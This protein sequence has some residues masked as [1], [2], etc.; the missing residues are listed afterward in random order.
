VDY[1]TFADS[2]AHRARVSRD[3]ADTLIFETL[4]VL[5]RTLP[6]K[7]AADL[8]AQLPMPLKRPLTLGPEEEPERLGLDEFIERVARRAAIPPEEARK[9]VEAVLTTV[10]EAVTE[11]EF[12]DVMA[13][14]P[15]EFW[16]VV[17]PRYWRS[18][19]APAPE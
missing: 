2:V 13:V 3:E 6:R 10:R 14:L 15:D 18:L 17:Q 4:D 7:E 16:R 8:A 19:L 1:D 5:A 9:G 11:G 12:E